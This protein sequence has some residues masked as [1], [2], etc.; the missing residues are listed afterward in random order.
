MGG[1]RRAVPAV[2]AVAVLAICAG[3]AAQAQPQSAESAAAGRAVVMVATPDLPIGRTSSARARWHE[4]RAESQQILQRV[5]ERNDL[6]I[7]SSNPQIGALSVSLGSEPLADLRRRLADDP[8]VEAVGPDIHAQL[9][10][11]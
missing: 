7:A 6:R 11:A 8:R 2:A 3:T 5:S 4:L 10:Y 9:E 1:M